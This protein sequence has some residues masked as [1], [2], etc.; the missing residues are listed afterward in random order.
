M[1][2]KSYQFSKVKTVEISSWRNMKEG[3]G[4]KGSV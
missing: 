2:R 1:D 3:K 4:G